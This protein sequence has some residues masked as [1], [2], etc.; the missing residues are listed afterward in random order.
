MLCICICA[1]AS[2]GEVLPVF[3]AFDKKRRSCGPS[4]AELPGLE[5]AEQGQPLMMISRGWRPVT[6][7]LMWAKKLSPAWAYSG[8]SGKEADRPRSISS[9]TCGAVLS[10]MLIPAA[11][12]GQK[13]RY[14][15][16]P[17]RSAPMICFVML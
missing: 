15:T 9:V 16:P 14:T 12:R 10:A 13:S 2:D 7:D 8:R 17:C 11:V 6:L 5:G 3:Q 4:N 1:D